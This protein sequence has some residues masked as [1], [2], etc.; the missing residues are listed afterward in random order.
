[1]YAV[2]VLFK[3]E[4]N[5]NLN[6]I[7]LSFTKTINFREDILCLTSYSVLNNFVC[8]FGECGESKL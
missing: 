7:G 3:F 6:D 5:E 1:M 8:K 2:D 4:F